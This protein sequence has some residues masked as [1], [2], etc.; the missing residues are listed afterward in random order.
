M[1][2]HR[3]LL[4]TPVFALAVLAGCSSNT[5]PSVTVVGDSVTSVEHAQLHAALKSDYTT[6]YIVSSNGRIGGMSSQ[7]SSSINSN[8]DPNVVIIN[9]G[10]IDALQAGSSTT[11]TTSGSP[12]A[13]LV[14]ATSGTGCVVLTTVNV[15]AD[16]RPVHIPDVTVATRINHQ[17]KS[18]A[19]SDP[20]KYKVVDWNEFL[21][22]LPAASVPTYLQ[23][24]DLVETPAGAAWLAKSDLAAVHSCGTARQPTVIGPNDA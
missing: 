19:H 3:F 21:A 24:N 7:L 5:V 16:D 14:S 8:G 4:V 2:R 17:I 1:R 11:S 10:T 12:L 15:R 9:L 22:T 6:T 13:P 20:T 23:R 18:L